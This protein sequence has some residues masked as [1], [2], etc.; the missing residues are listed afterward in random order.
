MDKY[1][2]IDP[3]LRDHLVSHINQRWAQLYE[4]EKEWGERSLRYLMLTNSGGAIATLSFLGAS[5]QALGL[6]GA[7]L[8]LLLFV[9]GIVL[10]GVTTAKAY[11]RIWGLFRAWKKDSEHFYEDRITW[12][13]LHTEDHMRARDNFWDYFFPYTSFACFIGGCLAGAVSLFS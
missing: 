9:V 11:H 12:E 3:S 4:L 6:T 5:H 7:K 1:S 13:Y 2:E 10:V 8:A